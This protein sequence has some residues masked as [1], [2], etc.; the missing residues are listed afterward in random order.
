MTDFREKSYW[1]QSDAHEPGQP[2][3]GDLDVDVAIVGGGFTGLSTAYF[4]SQDDPSLRIALLEQQVIGYGASG[5]NGG[6]SMTKIGMTHG[7]TKARFG[8]ARTIEAHEY[9]DRAV[10]QL[11]G[12]VEELQLECDYEH[13]GF[14]W[15]ATSE[16]F[17][18]RQRHELSLI[19]DLGIGGISYIDSDALAER[20]RSPLYVGGAWWEPNCGILNPAKLCWEWQRV[21][22]ASGVSIHE[23]TPVID[24]A[25][26]SAAG[27]SA[28][29]TPGGRVTARKVVFATNAWS[30]LL[31]PVR[32]RQ[33]P[34]W[35]SIVMTEPIAEERLAEAG[36]AGREGI[37]DFRDLVHYYRRTVD[38]R[39]AFGGRDIGLH[40][41]GSMDHDRDEPTFAA[42]R[43]D[44][45]KT[46][47]SL[48]DV[49]F[50][51][52]WGGPISATLDLFP[53]ITQVG[54]PDWIT[55]Y[56]CVGHGVSAT[57]LHGRTIADLVLERTTDLT[58]TFFVNRRVMPLPPGPLRKPILDG[59]AGF[60][61]WED[62]RYDVL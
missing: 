8:R 48:A 14:L 57:H 17:A 21:V 49:R 43:S 61:R 16:K 24:V 51:H 10:T 50:T 54:G 32:A 62:R 23:R 7:L 15:V 47:P 52:E 1:L 60:M 31:A 3:R 27:R 46:F 2:L 25:R 6:F 44:F 35:T 45:A 30:H 40:H 18:E 53:V 4:L 11:R 41:D 20:V 29:T 19:D 13:P 28:L 33:V 58:E 12:L 37:E 36:W 56:G 22:E 5:R 42:L 38:G 55:S 39:I 59:I 9:A 26:V 34:A